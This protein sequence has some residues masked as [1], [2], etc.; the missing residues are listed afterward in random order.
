MSTEPI[1][2]NELP[3][4][5]FEGRAHGSSVSMFFEREL[6]AGAGPRLHRHPYDETFVIQGGSAV[7]TLGDEE[8]VGS[9]GQ[10]LVAPAGLPHR[11]RSLG[12]YTAIHIHASDHF[13]Q[14][15]LE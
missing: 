7:F 15:W 10:I 8:V 14:E 5:D 4:G 3:G 13:I 11:F 2:R 9:A 1:E 12:G 6:P